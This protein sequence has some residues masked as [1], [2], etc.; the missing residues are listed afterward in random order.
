MLCVSPEFYAGTFALKRSN[1]QGSR[2]ALYRRFRRHQRDAEVL[3]A[4]SGVFRGGSPCIVFGYFCQYKSDAPGR[5]DQ[6]L[7][8]AR[9]PSGEAGSNNDKTKGLTNSKGVDIVFHRKGENLCSVQEKTS[10]IGGCISMK[11]PGSGLLKVVGILYVIFAGIGII[12]GLIGLAGIAALA[13][14]VGVSSGLLTFSA[15]IG[16]ASA[17]FRLFLGIVGIKHNN[18][19]EKAGFLRTLGIADVALAGASVIFGA[20][21]LGLSGLALELVGLVL[22]ILF[23]IGASKN[24]AAA[25]APQGE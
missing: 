17:A 1:P 15:L 22:P 10:I 12:F 4:W 18:N 14:L 19:L 23:L 11:A 16:L 5:G 2:S 6:P 9:I 13:A 7:S 20:V 25:R 8:S 21:L 3:D 24:V